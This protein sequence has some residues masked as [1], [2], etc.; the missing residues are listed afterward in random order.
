MHAAW[1]SPYTTG[2]SGRPARPSTD[3]A[4]APTGRPMS[5]VSA[6]VVGL[7]TKVA[8]PASARSSARRSRIGLLIRCSSNDAD[9]AVLRATT[10]LGDGARPASKNSRHA[11][12]D[13]SA[14]LSLP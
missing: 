4:V 8:S 7:P 12:A 5:L 10:A 6:L 13:A 11:D 1:S 3:A 9:G 2:G 14:P